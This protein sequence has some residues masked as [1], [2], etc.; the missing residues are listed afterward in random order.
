M[1]SSSLRVSLAALAL[2]TA[3]A[4]AGCKSS[5]SKPAES[6]DPGC[7]ADVG[8]DINVAVATG[9]EGVKTGAKT[10]V[11]GVKTFGAGAAGLVEG[12][13]DEAK[14]RWNEGAE[15]TRETANEGAQNTRRKGLPRC[16]K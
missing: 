8:D 6:P 11:E 13:K 3:A 7:R 2:S 12:G 9:A 15:K 5:E 16:T 10:A 14:V 4:L 1:L